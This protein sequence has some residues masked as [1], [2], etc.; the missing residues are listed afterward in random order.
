MDMHIHMS[1]LTSDGFK[2][3][4]STYLNVDNDHPLLPEIDDLI[5]K[6][7]VTPAEVAEE[8]MKTDDVDSSLEEVL[9]F[10]NNKE[11]SKNKNV[12][13]IHDHHD[14]ETKAKEVIGEDSDI[15]IRKLL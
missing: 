3:L 9:K 14:D 6:N 15:Q 8:L 7:D 11:A 10:L 4:A 2:H 1:Y 12:E 13:D 5:R